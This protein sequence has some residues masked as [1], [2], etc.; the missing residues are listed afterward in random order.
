MRGGALAARPVALARRDRA[1]TGR[2]GGI[3]APEA[4]KGG[5]VAL[6]TRPRGQIRVVLARAEGEQTASAAS[7]QP[8]AN[9]AACDVPPGM[10]DS[11]SL[12]E[13]FCIIEGGDNQVRDFA[14]MDAETLTEVE[15]RTNLEE[16]P[17]ASFGGLA[18]LTSV[19]LSQCLQLTALL[20]GLFRGLTSLATI[21]M[22]GNTGLT[23]LPEGLFCGLTALETIDMYGNKGLTSLPEGLFV[24]LTALKTVD[25]SRCPAATPAVLERL[26]S[27]GVAVTEEEV[28][29]EY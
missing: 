2:N 19:N 16:M 1:R 8:E 23:S 4:P 22:D 17:F 18:K 12:P 28:D 26:R 27:S 29:E 10:L 20:E 14:D 7:A 9:G 3:A 15:M 6:P 11:Q 24:G 25:M 21:K 13:N 5:L